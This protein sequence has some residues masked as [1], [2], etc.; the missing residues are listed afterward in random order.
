MWASYQGHLD[1][2]LALV[3]AG[4]NVNAATRAGKTALVAL[5]P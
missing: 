5:K 3:D 2:I 1:C 4:G